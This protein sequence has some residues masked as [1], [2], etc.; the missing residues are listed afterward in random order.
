MRHLLLLLCLPIF[1]T[2]CAAATPI[3]VTLKAQSAVSANADG[4]FSLASIAALSGG[5]AAERKRM[6]AICV[7]RAPLANEVRRLT[8]GDI[9]LKLR[10]A[11]FHPETDAIIEGA[12]Q[13]NVTVDAVQTLGADSANISGDAPLN[14]LA[15]AIPHAVG[16]EPE[17]ES[18]LLIHRGDA[19]TIVVQEDGLSITAKGVARDAGRA[20]DLIHVHREGVMTDLSVTVLDSQNVQLEL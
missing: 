5:N 14:G 13:V 10:Q 4:F 17:A 19:V 3:H 18:P 20:G 9:S 2:A 7:G 16:A 15:S 8:P 6:G 12:A 1:S 11:G